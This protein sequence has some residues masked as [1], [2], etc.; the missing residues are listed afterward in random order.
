MTQDPNEDAKI[1]RRLVEEAHK[2]GRH[3]P[4]AQAF[5]ELKRRQDEI[6]RRQEEIMH[7]RQREPGEM[8]EASEIKRRHQ[9]TSAAI[10]AKYLTGEIVDAEFE[11]MEKK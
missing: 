3:R 4:D 8:F 9:E 5:V 10:K 6:R 1:W 7:G 2:P 11:V